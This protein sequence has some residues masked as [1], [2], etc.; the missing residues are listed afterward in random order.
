MRSCA[1]LSTSLL[2]YMFIS[3]NRIRGSCT[4]ICWLA[5]R[6]AAAPFT[7]HLSPHPCLPLL[8]VPSCVPPTVRVRAGSPGAW[9]HIRHEILHGPR[10]PLVRNRVCVCVTISEPFSCACM[11]LPSLPKFFRLLDD[12]CVRPDLIRLPTHTWGSL[13]MSAASCDV[14][15][16]HPRTF[17]PPPNCH[18]LKCVCVCVC[19]TISRESPPARMHRPSHSGW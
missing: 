3:Q 10:R 14:A 7:C 1:Y 11:S 15:L 17:L 6:C 2:L 18:A 5:R 12:V 8:L 9:S 13:F 16:A 4:R 19:V